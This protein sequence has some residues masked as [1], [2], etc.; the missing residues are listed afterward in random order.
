MEIGHLNYLTEAKKIVKF[1]L[2]WSGEVVYSDHADGNGHYAAICKS[3]YLV[4]VDLFES[5]GSALDESFLLQLGEACVY[6]L[7]TCEKV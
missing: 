5:K 4:T 6:D 3:Q 2:G 1:N 7:D